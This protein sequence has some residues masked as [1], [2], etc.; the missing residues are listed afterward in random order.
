MALRK[1]S[2]DYLRDTTKAQ[3]AEAKLQ[4]RKQRQDLAKLRKEERYDKMLLC[5]RVEVLAERACLQ[6]KCAS[7]QNLKSN[8][9]ET[10]I[11]R[12][13]SNSAASLQSEQ[14]PADSQFRRQRFSSQFSRTR[15]S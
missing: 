13:A 11:E 6:S 2:A 3:N 14:T 10:S 12:H 9:A 15:R 1:N 8:D 4:K 5:R 7:W